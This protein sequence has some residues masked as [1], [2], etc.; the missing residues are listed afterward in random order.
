MGLSTFPLRKYQKFWRIRRGINPGV[1][2]KEEIPMKKP[3][4]TAITVCCLL[5]VLAYMPE[6]ST[7]AQEDPFAEANE[8]NASIEEEM[9]WLQAETY[10]ITASRVLENIKK[11]ASSITVITDSQFR[12]MGARY[13]ADVLRTVPGMGALY[14]HDQTYRIDA[15]GILKGSGQHILFMI[16]SHPLN[17]NFSGGAMLLYDT[18]LLDNVQRIEVIRGPGSALYGANA[19][20]GVINIITKSAEE[21]DGIQVTARGGSFQTQEYN[22]L[23]GKSFGE[24][25]IS[26]NAQYFDTEGAEVYIEQDS[27]TQIDQLGILYGFP[28]ASRAPDDVSTSD[29]K[30]DVSL[31]LAY[32]GFSF[33]GHYVERDKNAPISL[34]GALTDKN[35]DQINTYNLMVGYENEIHEKLLFSGKLYRNHYASKADY[36]GYPPGTLVVTPDGPALLGSDGAIVQLDRKENR[37]GA[38]VVATYTPGETH[39]I[40]AGGSYEHMELYDVEYAANFLYTPVQ[41][42]IVLLPAIQDLSDPSTNYAKDADRTFQALFLEDLWDIREDM[43]ITVGARYD[44]YS[45]FGSSFNPRAGLTWEFI[46]GYDVKLLYGKAFRAPSFIELYA[47][48]NP[49]LI[50]NPDLEPEIVHTYEVSAG[51]EITD[52]LSGR[53]TGFFSQI[54]DSINQVQTEEGFQYQNADE[55]QSQGVEMEARY[56]FGKGTYLTAS[57]TYQDVEYEDTGERYQ[58]APQHKGSILTNFRI[59]KYLNLSAD[60]YFQGKYTRLDN[61]SR[62]DIEGFAV[63]NTTLIA[64]NFLEGLEVRGSIYN[65]LDTEYYYPSSADTLPNDVPQ[66]G[67]SFLVELLYDF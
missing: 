49:A 39:T 12:K 37:T 16:N 32:K 57:Y 22:V 51:A 17:E 11:S 24:F 61:D 67:R 4:I 21:I 2:L 50:G 14:E 3:V 54:F 5:L 66:P 53:V 62:D 60:A 7:F 31:G 19:F 59:S 33:E 63:L 56:D 48:N 27:I 65:V 23:F 40:V 26:A 13:L 35:Q 58:Y 15:R 64:K 10:V 25:T 34:T 28:A 36:Q 41:N 9:E 20:A 1:L 45:D 47:Q 8:L 29:Q 43:R 38:E 44:S 6:E 52:A 30:Y 46:P 42:V 18:A 55:L